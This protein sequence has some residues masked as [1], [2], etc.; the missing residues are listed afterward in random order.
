MTTNITTEFQQQFDTLLRD[1]ADRGAL[2]QALAE[3]AQRR[4]FGD[5][6]PIWAPALYAR[7]AVFFESF[8]VRR[9]DH[10]ATI[11]ELLPRAEADGH[12][13]LFQGLYAKIAGE[14]RWNAEL[15]ALA[16]SEQPDE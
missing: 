14:E 12:D 4:G 9:L 11:G 6:A 10:A 15:R 1:T 16:R 7:D 13:T 8:L 3:L 5:L 2:L